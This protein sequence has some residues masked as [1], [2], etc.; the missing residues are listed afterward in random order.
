MRLVGLGLV[1]VGRRIAVVK[2]L[3]LI[4]KKRGTA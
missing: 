4:N 1:I 2:T 3:G